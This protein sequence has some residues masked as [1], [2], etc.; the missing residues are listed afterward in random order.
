MCR[1]A[2][3]CAMVFEAIE[4]KDPLDQTS[5]DAPFLFDHK[6]KPKQYKVG[7]LKNLIDMDSTD[8][9][10]N[11]RKALKKLKEN[12]INPIPIELPKNFPHNV[13]DIILRAESGAFFDELVRSGGVDKMVQQHQKSRANSLRQSRFIPAVEYLQANRFRGELIEEMHNL[14]N[15]FDVLISPTFG[16]RQLMTS[17]LTGH[18]VVC[19]PTGFDNQNHPTSISFLGNLYEE[20]KILEFANFFQAITNFHLKYPPLYFPSKEDD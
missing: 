16:G 20:D 10:D 17:N 4:G 18:P 9:G 15:K 14:M 3:G 13:F 5:V 8:S 7:Y 2:I 6:A 19:V 1:S 12:G 11:L